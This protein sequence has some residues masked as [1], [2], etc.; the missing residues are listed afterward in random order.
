MF[1]KII[2]YFNNKQLNKELKQNYFMLKK[3]EVLNCFLLVYDN[4]FKYEV[5]YKKEQPV[6]FKLMF[7]N[8]NQLNKE[9]YAKYN[10]KKAETFEKEIIDYINAAFE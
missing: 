9:F 10:E 3:I 2:N 7:E 8:N 6:G 5:I 4:K 1:D